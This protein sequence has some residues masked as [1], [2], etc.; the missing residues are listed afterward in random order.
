M[1][2]ANGA[3]FLR[4]GVSFGRPAHP[5]NM[6]CNNGRRSFVFLSIGLVLILLVAV[7]AC[8]RPQTGGPNVGLVTFLSGSAQLVR[9]GR[10]VPLKMQDRFGPGDVIRTGPQGIVVALLSNKEAEIEIQP[11]AEFRIEEYSATSKKLALEKGN[12]WLRVN[13]R[14]K[15]E[16][17][18]LRSPTAIAGVRGTKFYTFQFQ[19]SRGRTYN[20]VCHCEGQVD[21]KTQSGRAYNAVHDG[22][23]LVLVRDGKTI[24]ITAPELKF[25]GPAANHQHS[26]LADSPL[27]PRAVQMTPAQQMAFLELVER[28]FAAVR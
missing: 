23:Q 25:M 8:S 10:E 17:F 13:R 28:K 24:L 22:D 21:F 18:T 4:E 15:G 20:G 27:G 2:D 14:A 19:D 26:A 1:K 11:N 12:L 9:N 6:K 3:F 16:D 7:S 5:R